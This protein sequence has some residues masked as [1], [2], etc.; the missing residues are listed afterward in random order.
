MSDAEK[1]HPVEFKILGKDYKVACTAD[2][3][4]KL[5]QSALEL[6][7]Q[8]RTIRDTGKVSSVDR[9]AVMAALNLADELRQARGYIA[10]PEESVSNKIAELR[11]KIE[12]VLENC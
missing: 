9:I 12:K 5:V 10:N 6:D 4:E 2:E 7:L 3:Q 1:L 11:N 8:M